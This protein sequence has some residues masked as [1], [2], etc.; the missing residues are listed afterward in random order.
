ML[1]AE[2]IERDVRDP[3]VHAAGLV[4]VNLVELNR[5]MSV[6]R[7]YVSFLGGDT[8]E[9]GVDG[10]V[11]GLQA[12]AGFLRGPLARRMGLRRAPELRFARDTRAAF[13]Q[14]IREILQEDDAR[15]HGGEAAAG[16]DADPDAGVEERAGAEGVPAGGHREGDG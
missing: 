7:V 5:D 12:A 13:G 15:G 9:R 6:A 3:R 16:L 2:M 1:L 11:A 10:A 4:S 14:Q 8:G